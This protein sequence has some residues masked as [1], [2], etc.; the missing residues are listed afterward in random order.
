MIRLCVE[1]SL[2]G[3]TSKCYFLFFFLR[4]SW[5]T[6]YFFCIAHFSNVLCFY[7]KI[8]YPLN[9]K[10][11]D[12]DIYAYIDSYFIC[13]MFSKTHFLTRSGLVFIPLPNFQLSLASSMPCIFSPTSLCS[14]YSFCLECPPMNPSLF[15]ILLYLPNFQEQPRLNSRVSLKH[16]PKFS[17]HSNVFPQLLWCLK[18]SVCMR[19]CWRDCQPPV[20][21][22]PE[23]VSVELQ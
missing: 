13:S 8:Y 22:P 17:L 18:T 10:K 16:F 6:L 20:F 19:S 9:Q 11:L 14:Y 2:R 12:I 5:E 7:T 15:Q 4:R 3:S 1:K 23:I 21:L